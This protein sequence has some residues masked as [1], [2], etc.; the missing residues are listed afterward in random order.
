MDTKVTKTEWDFDE[1][2]SVDYMPYVFLCA[3]FA[4][5]AM[6]TCAISYV[7][8]VSGVALIVA[9]VVCLFCVGFALNRDDGKR[10]IR[11]AVKITGTPTTEAVSVD[12]VEETDSA[13]QHSLAAKFRR[14]GL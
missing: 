13:F 12:N 1:M 8:S 2:N 10:P 3:C 9:S 4:A 5:A 14:A 7:E 11:S 6:L